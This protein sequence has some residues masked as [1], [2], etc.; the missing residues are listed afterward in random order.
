MQ[1]GKRQLLRGDGYALSLGL[2]SG[3]CVCV[4]VK[5]HQALMFV[6]FTVYTL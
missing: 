4:H 3:L 6:H 1:K 2:D 5:S